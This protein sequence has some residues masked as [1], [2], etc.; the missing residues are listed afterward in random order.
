MQFKF[1]KDKKHYLFQFFLNAV[2]R[3]LDGHI[4]EFFFLN[5]CLDGLNKEGST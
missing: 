3:E 2:D 5:L 4:K 1:V